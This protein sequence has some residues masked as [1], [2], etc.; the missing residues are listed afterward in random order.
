[1]GESPCLGIA[2][3]EE[4]QQRHGPVARER[5]AEERIVPGVVEACE[6]GKP[7]GIGEGVEQ[8]FRIGIK[9]LRADVGGLPRLGEFQAL[10]RA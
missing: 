4:G 2:H 9:R 1:M 7:G 10:S 6:S 8:V 3:A 5:Q